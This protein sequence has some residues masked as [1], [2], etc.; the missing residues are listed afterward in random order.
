MGQAWVAAQ[1]GLETLF[2]FF[3]N[4]EK[5][6]E[7]LQQAGVER[8]DFWDLINQFRPGIVA[9]ARRAQVEVE[10]VESEAWLAWQ[11]ANQASCRGAGWWWRAVQKS[12]L[13]KACWWTGGP[14]WCGGPTP[15]LVPVEEAEFEVVE[16]AVIERWRGP[17]GDLFCDLSPEKL[18]KRLGVSTRRAQQIIKSATAASSEPQGDL[19]YVGVAK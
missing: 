12:V 18:A 6:M 11:A 17:E 15:R 8:H 13:R 9:L 4:G 19:F 2:Q 16:A 7:I 3:G 10:E 14:L 1:A 5:A